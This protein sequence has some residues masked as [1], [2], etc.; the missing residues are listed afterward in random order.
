MSRGLKIGDRV[1]TTQW[2]R[3]KRYHTGD[4]GTVLRTLKMHDDGLPFCL[5]AMDRDASHGAGVLFD[6]N[7]ID[8]DL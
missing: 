1:Y 2:N 5:V 4:K 8:A 3:Q 6:T 7:E